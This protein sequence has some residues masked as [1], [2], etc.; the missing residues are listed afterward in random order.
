MRGTQN[1][2]PKMNAQWVRKIFPA[3][4]LRLTSVKA[5]VSMLARGISPDTCP[6]LI[7]QIGYEANRTKV[8]G[9]GTNGV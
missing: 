1:A 5:V 6:S 3:A 9:R 2:W 8:R 7:A 4:G